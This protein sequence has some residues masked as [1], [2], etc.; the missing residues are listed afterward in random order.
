MMRLVNDNC[1]PGG[2]CTGIDLML[3]SHVKG[4]MATLKDPMYM[5]VA[6]IGY[7]GNPGNKDGLYSFI[8]SPEQ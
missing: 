8:Q 7:F 4:S 1:I 5:Y 3:V 6:L 2:S